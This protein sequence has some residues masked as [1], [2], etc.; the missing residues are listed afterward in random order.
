MGRHATEKS[1]LV[2]NAYGPGTDP[3][4]PRPAD[5]SVWELRVLLIPCTPVLDC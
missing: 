1:A 4:D 3:E 5:I 2:R